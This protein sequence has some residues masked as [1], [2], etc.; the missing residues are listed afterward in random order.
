MSDEVK[1]LTDEEA[2]DAAGQQWLE[3][4]AALR[5]RSAEVGPEWSQERAGALLA[6]LAQAGYTFIK[7]DDL[8]DDGITP[9]S[10]VATIAERDGQIAV[11][12]TERDA[13]VAVTENLRTNWRAS[14]T[15][16]EQA[17]ARATS[18][19]ATCERL[20]EERNAMLERMFDLC[21][22]GRV[23]SECVDTS[24]GVGWNACI[25]WMDSAL[26]AVRSSMTQADGERR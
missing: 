17:T 15:A 26:C 22:Q 13:A 4:V 14:E 3:C 24:H 1:S 10:C 18:A 2:L 11:L 25:T 20:R 7:F 8:S 16:E 23:A 9:K 6:V 12:T 21:R 5:K 19:E